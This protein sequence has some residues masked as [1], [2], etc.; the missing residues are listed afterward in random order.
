[1]KGQ[2]AKPGVIGKAFGDGP[3]VPKKT[4][5][6]KIDYDKIAEHQK[7]WED[8]A[9]TSSPPFKM[10]YT[11]EEKVAQTVAH[12]LSHGVSVF[13]HGESVDCTPND[14]SDSTRYVMGGDGTLIKKQLA[15]LDG[16]I[17]GKGNQESGD[18]SCFMVYNPFCDWACSKLSDSII[19]YYVSPFALGKTLC[20]SNAG[21][22]INATPNYFG[23]AVKGNCLSQI[24]L[25]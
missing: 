8:F 4:Y 9:R 6:I 3:G 14:P 20:K 7:G 19:I 1:V 11:L 22:G 21:T 10:P 23:D 5:I 13:H 2:I 15:D 25:K 16:I 24:K 18:L 12:E 17:G